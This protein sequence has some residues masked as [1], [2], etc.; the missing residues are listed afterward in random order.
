MVGMAVRDHHHVDVLRLVAGLRHTRDQVA[1]RQATLELLVLGAERAVTGVEQHQLLAGIDHDRSERMKVTVGFDAVGGGQRLHLVGLRLA[2][3]CGRQPR[4]DD[5]TVHERGDF[6]S[7]QL[8]AVD[9]RL[10][11]TLH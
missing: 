1:G 2:A 9:G 5:M 4:A 3:E 11:F 6:K 10:D 7:A 8:E